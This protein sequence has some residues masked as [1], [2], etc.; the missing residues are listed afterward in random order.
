MFID[1]FYPTVWEVTQAEKVFTNEL[2]K[3]GLD[4]TSG[5]I[6]KKTAIKLAIIAVW[7]AGR[8][9]QAGKQNKKN[10]AKQL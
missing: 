10:I 6:S 4:C 9:Y 5:V 3:D 7:R 8:E 1:E 2:S